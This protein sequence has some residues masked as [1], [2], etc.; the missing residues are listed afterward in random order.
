MTE[1][2]FQDV[3]RF[4]EETPESI[5]QL[6]IAFASQELRWKPALNEFSA[7]EQVCHLRDL[8]REGYAARISKLLTENQP[9]LP[10]FDGGRVARERDYNTQD[11]ESACQAF[12]LARAENV[13]LI[14]SLLPEQLN[15]SGV[16]EGIGA[17]TLEKLLLL[18]RGHDQSHRKELSELQERMP[19]ERK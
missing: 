9:S 15:R 2:E 16:L 5:R 4:L 1:Q 17:I 6:T 8:E 18:M 11:F 19:G 13:R 12:A 7:L 14:K 3:V 10:D